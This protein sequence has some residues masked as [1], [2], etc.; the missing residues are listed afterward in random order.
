MSELGL[1]PEQLHALAQTGSLT[2][3]APDSPPPATYQAAYARVFQRGWPLV[4]SSDW[5]G[6]RFFT[7]YGFVSENLELRQVTPLLQRMLQEMIH[8]SL[9]QYHY[10][11]GD[12][13]EA[14]WRNTAY[15]CVAARLLNPDAPT[16]F[17]VSGIVR[18]ELDLIQAAAGESPSPL[19]SLDAE[20]ESLRRP[21]GPS[22]ASTTACSAPILSSGSTPPGQA[23]T[24]PCS[25]SAKGPCRCGRSSPSSRR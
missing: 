15:L 1:T 18:Q 9:E 2:I 19:F 25:G 14:A 22:A 3:E 6:E 20:R 24:S 13:K 7:M 11:A 8:A 17:I 16:P 10:S 4:W 23:C 12:L 21:G 5:A